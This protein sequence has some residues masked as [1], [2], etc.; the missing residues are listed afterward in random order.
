MEINNKQYQENTAILSLDTSSSEKPIMNY[1]AQP[2][3]RINVPPTEHEQT[4]FPFL[5]GHDKW[6]HKVEK[7]FTTALRLIMKSGTSKIKI[8]NKNYG[9]NELISLYIRYETGEVRTKKQ[10]SSH[11]QVWKKSILSKASS[12][13]R[14]TSIDTE[15]L[16]LIEK[17]AEQNKESLEIFYSTFEVIIDTL[18]KDT[19]IHNGPKNPYAST[20]PNVTKLYPQPYSRNSS[21]G[22]NYNNMA[23]TLIDPHM[24]D[25]N[26]H[27][28]PRYQ[29]AGNVNPYVDQQHAAFSQ[30]GPLRYTP[31]EN[32]SMQQNDTV[33]R[34]SSNDNSN[35]V[36][37]IQRAYPEYYNAPVE[38]MEERYKQPY[39]D[40]RTGQM[41][42]AYRNWYPGVQPRYQSDFKDD[43]LDAPPI[44][45]PSQYSSSTASLTP[46]LPVNQQFT[47]IDKQIPPAYIQPVPMYSEADRIKLPHLVQ[48]NTFI[49]NTT[50]QYNAMYPNDIRG[51]NYSVVQN[52]DY[53]SASNTAN[54]QNAVNS[55]DVSNSTPMT[56]PSITTLNTGKFSEHPHEEQGTK[57][58]A[59]FHEPS[60]RSE[61][62]LTN[63]NQMVHTAPYLYQNSPIQHN[64]SNI[65]IKQQMVMLPT[66]PYYSQN[67]PSQVPSKEGNSESL[68]GIHPK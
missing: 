22:N 32:Y 8:R 15:I 38:Q 24:A 54:N 61:V 17:G 42:G 9:R 20:N 63:N 25:S 53:N 55:N 18:L 50:G 65:P 66:Y 41:A 31:V 59:S 39:H 57:P 5:Y 2:I 11:I 47:N 56:N 33:I 29:Y 62:S 43:N 44:G 51:S 16:N 52:K 49:G 27:G 48:S 68:P 60:V 67:I 4:M 45:Y 26:A 21:Y 12:N 40:N 10:I 7:A 1:P 36:I 13:M 46:Q 64:S 19:T 23:P 30:G 58:M 37:G 14:L 6:P 35:K 3:A 28:I 34:Y